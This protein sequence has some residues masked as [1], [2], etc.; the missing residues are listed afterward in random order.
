[1]VFPAMILFSFRV[2]GC[3]VHI[4][5]ERAEHSGQYYRQ[6]FYHQLAARFIFSKI[7]PVPRGLARCELAGCFGSGLWSEQARGGVEASRPE[8]IEENLKEY[9]FQTLAE[10]PHAAGGVLLRAD[11]V[12]RGSG[13][14]R[15]AQDRQEKTWESFDGAQ[16][17]P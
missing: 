14:R 7:P 17:L 10:R 1:M 9:D 12:R 16:R 11:L 13:G 8:Q 15:F 6:I 2:A 3:V 5:D 4:C